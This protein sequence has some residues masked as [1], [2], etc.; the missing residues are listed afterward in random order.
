MSRILLGLN[1]IAAASICSTQVSTILTTI[2]PYQGHPATLHQRP[3]TVR[4]P[5]AIPVAAGAPVR[6]FTSAYVCPLPAAAATTVA[7]AGLR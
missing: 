5:S 1:L 6:L 4:P 7:V 2:S 3:A